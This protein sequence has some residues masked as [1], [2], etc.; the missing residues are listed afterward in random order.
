MQLIDG[1]RLDQYLR[2]K[3]KDTPRTFETPRKRLGKF[4]RW[5]RERRSEIREAFIN[6]DKTDIQSATTEFMSEL[7]ERR[8]RRRR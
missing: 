7:P 1:H 3:E 8:V 4:S 2:M 6:P 5:F